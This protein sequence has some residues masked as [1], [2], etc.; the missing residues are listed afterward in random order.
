MQA[1]SLDQPD[2]KMGRR[3]RDP[4]PVADDAFPAEMIPDKRKGRYGRQNVAVLAAQVVAWAGLLTLIEAVG[5]PWKAVGVVL[6]CFVMQGVFSMMHEYFHD[7]A[8]PDAR[9]GYG[10]GLVGSTLFGTSATL[11]RVN[12]WGHHVRNRTPAEQGEFIH[13]GESVLGKVSLY[14]FAVT[15][16][17][18]LS[19]L[20]FPFIS[21]FVPF[22]AVEWL[23]SHRRYNTYSAAF[24]S[25]KAADWTRMRLEAVGLAA[26][27]GPVIVWGPWSVGTLGLAYLA[28]AFSWSSLQWVYHLRTPLHVVE[29]AYNLRLPTPIRW[30]FL[31][32]NM[33]LT[34]HRRPY[35]PWQELYAVTDQRETQP[36]WYRWLLMFKPPMR[37][38]KRAEDLAFLEK[39]YF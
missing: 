5:W 22:R 29:G 14:Y 31:N 38:P 30:L 1:M 36:L 35:L 11:H 24:A 34:H 13:E 32:F 17:L 10:I 9:I 21:I 15:I 8:H 16:G 37:F 7:N 2:K 23:S 19:G 20:V 25:F 26:F 12:H 3:L 28:F 18:W 39:R 6:F 4:E 33:N 27:W